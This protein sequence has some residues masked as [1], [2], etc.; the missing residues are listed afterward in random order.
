MCSSPLAGRVEFP[1]FEHGEADFHRTPLT[2]WFWLI[3]PMG[4]QKSSIIMLSLYRML[5]IENSKGMWTMGPKIRQAMADLEAAHVY[6]DASHMHVHLPHNI[7]KAKSIIDF[8]F[9]QW[10]W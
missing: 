1:R 7:L 10:P 3:W 2:K 5:D 8:E 4:R 6:P 9:W